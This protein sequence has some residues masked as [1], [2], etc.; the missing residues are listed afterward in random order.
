LLDNVRF[1]IDHTIL[2]YT[3]V[4]VAAPYGQHSA[5]APDTECKGAPD[6]YFSGSSSP[7]NPIN[8]VR[9]ASGTKSSFETAFFG[10]DG[11]MYHPNPNFT[12]GTVHGYSPVDVTRLQDYI[13][14]AG[15]CTGTLDAIRQNQAASA[16]REGCISP[17]IFKSPRFALLPVLNAPVMPPNG[18]SYY[19]CIGF[20]ALFIDKDDSDMS[21]SETGFTWN[22]GSMRIVKGYV[23]D[24]KY[25]P[26]TVS[27]T[28]VG[29]TQDYTGS[30]PKIPL[31]V[32]DTGDGTY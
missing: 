9:L 27:S 8:C 25:L 18:T 13:S 7:A 3:G 5:P 19:W 24:V 30:G 31:L 17:K 26:E 12:P 16:L 2:S 28:Q 29:G 23:F 11:R 32:H 15:S 10:A 6:S 22:G 14:N 21:A 20:K 4:D 1:G